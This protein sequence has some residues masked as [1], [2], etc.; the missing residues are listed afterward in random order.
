MTDMQVSLTHTY[1]SCSMKD[2]RAYLPVRLRPSHLWLS[3]Q[4][5]LFLPAQKPQDPAAMA[6]KAP[7]MHGVFIS[8]CLV[9]P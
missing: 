9:L 2:K 3:M 5:F 8:I 7:G 4:Q 6:V 1:V